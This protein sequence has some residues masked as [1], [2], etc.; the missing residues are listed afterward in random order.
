MNAC[1]KKEGVFAILAGH[2]PFEPTLSCCG[3]LLPGAVGSKPIAN[4]PCKRQQ[5]V[6]S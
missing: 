3:R 2:E 4:C 1:G 6:R 5:K